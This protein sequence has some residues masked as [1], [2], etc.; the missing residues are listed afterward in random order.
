M[1]NFSKR[2]VLDVMATVLFICSV[3]FA[4]QWVFFASVSIF[5]L[6]TRFT[7][8]SEFTINSKIK[9]RADGAY[10]GDLWKGQR[11]YVKTVEGMIIGMEVSN[12]S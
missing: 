8:A 12:E 10:T 3:I 9:S 6:T 2:D 7:K 11:A 4:N 1:G 5:I